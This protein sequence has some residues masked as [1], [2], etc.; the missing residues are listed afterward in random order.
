VHAKRPSKRS[1]S[2]HL[3]G[4]FIVAGVTARDAVV[5]AVPTKANIDLA[6]AE[7]AV[8]FAPAFFFR[9]F[10]LHAT[11]SGSS[12]WAR[13]EGTVMSGGSNGKVPMVTSF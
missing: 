11:I 5:K 13:H 3:I 4:D 2:K 12:R 10:A 7:A 1:S 8:F 9:H 6:L